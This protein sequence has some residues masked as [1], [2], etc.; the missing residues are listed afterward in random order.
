ME[1]AK[2]PFIKSIIE[3]AVRHLGFFAET[4]KT[5]IGVVDMLRGKDIEQIYAFYL[6]PEDLD[7]CGLGTFLDSLSNSL[8]RMGR[9][10][11]LPH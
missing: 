6:S 11:L 7:F 8:G 3:D 5:L 1:E 4:H 10:R 2:L 9:T